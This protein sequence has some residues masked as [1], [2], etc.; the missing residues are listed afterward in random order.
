MHFADGEILETDMIV[1][2]AGVRPDDKLARAADL[3]LGERGVASSSITTAVPAT[4][5]FIAIGEC[6]LWG[7]RIF[8]LG[9]ARY[10]M[11]KVAASQL[12]GGELLFPGRRYEHEIEIAR[13]RCRL[14]RRQSCAPAKAR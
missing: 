11:A 14:D 8:G 12:S 5:V 6:A 10:Q 13:R 7:G 1:F 2:S 9:R 4:K 3:K